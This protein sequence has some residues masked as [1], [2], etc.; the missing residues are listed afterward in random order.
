MLSSDASH[1]PGRRRVDQ[2][3]GGTGEHGDVQVLLTVSHST[4]DADIAWVSPYAKSRVVYIQPG[5]GRETHE[6]PWYRQLVH[7]AIAWAGGR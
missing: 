1:F 4:S 2:V 7:N 5:H 3:R 6:S